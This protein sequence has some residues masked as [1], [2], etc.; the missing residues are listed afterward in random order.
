MSSRALLKWR[1][2]RA[3]ELD[4]IAKAHLIVGGDARGRRY[5]TQQINHAY[6]T[7]LSSQ[8]QG[9][10]RDLHGEAVH[11]FVLSLPTPA[12]PLVRAQLTKD[13]TVDRGNPTPGNLEKDFGRLDLDLWAA[14]YAL[15]P[16]NRVRNRKLEKL[17]AWRNAIAHHDFTK[18]HLLAFAG[19]RMTLRLPDVRAWRSA[20]NGLASNMDRVVG[21]TWRS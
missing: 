6:A 11:Y 17:I 10:C 3:V 20:C 7:L 8:W 18:L 16:R 5:A 13:R 15:D 2:E 14:L 4:Q 21:T 1:S 19:G 12:Q 9:F